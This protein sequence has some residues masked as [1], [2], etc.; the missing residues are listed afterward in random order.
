MALE[1]KPFTDVAF[2]ATETAAAVQK[3]VELSTHAY[4]MGIVFQLTGTV[5]VANNNGSAAGN[6]LLALNL[7]RNVRLEGDGNRHYIQ[8]CD[9]AQLARRQTLLQGVSAYP[10]NGGTTVAAHA[11]EI[12][13]HIPFYPDNFGEFGKHP[14]AP[15]FGLPAHKHDRLTLWYDERPLNEAITPNAAGDLSEA[16]TV[17]VFGIYDTDADR[18][19]R[20]HEVRYRGDSLA[21]AASGAGQKLDLKGDY[22]LRSLYL[23]AFDNTV[24]AD[25]I[26]TNVSLLIK[27]GGQEIQPFNSAWNSYQLDQDRLSGV[28]HITGGLLLMLDQE[29]DGRGIEPL[30]TASYAKFE[31]TVGS[32]TAT[33]E[34]KT[35]VEELHFAK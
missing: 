33:S 28:A 22:A 15:K 25:S 29:G 27:R 31:P 2:T 16:L 14:D 8:N 5:T 21:F 9:L 24:A 23:D 32:P 10:S 20:R 13:V 17:R 11:V 18:S 30:G 12:S 34:V 35:V 26:I 1:K 6:G 19:V 4:L 7:I 3:S